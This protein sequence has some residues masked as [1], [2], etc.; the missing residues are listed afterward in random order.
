MPSILR[1]Y[2]NDIFISYRQ[3]DNKRNGGVTEFID[4]LKNELETNLSI[5]KRLG[6]LIFI[7]IYFQRK[8]FYGCSVIKA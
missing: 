4:S 3:N 2:E 7:Q 8:L 6:C 1:N 5:A